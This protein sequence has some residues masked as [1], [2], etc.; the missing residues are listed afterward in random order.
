MTSFAVEDLKDTELDLAVAVAISLHTHPSFCLYKNTPATF[1]EFEPDAA[2]DEHCLK[3]YKNYKYFRPSCQWE[4]GGP[5]L[6]TIPGLNI[7]QCGHIWVATV[8]V[9]NGSILHI[10]ESLLEAAM[11][12]LVEFNFKSHTIYL[13]KINDQTPEE[14]P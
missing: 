1:T 8:D 11:R 7:A 3:T 6:E 13:P 12:V 4:R 14:A 5:L 9:E 2:A 10:G